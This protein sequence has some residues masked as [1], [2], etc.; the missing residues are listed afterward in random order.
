MT[1]P[2]EHYSLQPDAWRRF[3]LRASRGLLLTV[4]VFTPLAFGTSEVWSMTVAQTLI[5]S[6]ALL[7]LVALLPG[8]GAPV[9]YRVPGMAPLLLLTCFML[10]QL[11]P[12]PPFLLTWISPST[13]RIYAESVWLL[14]PGKW[15]PL[16]LYYANTLSELFRFSACVTLYFL[17]VQLLSHRKFLHRASALLALLAGSIAFFALLQKFSSPDTIYWFRHVEGGSVTGPWVYRNHYAGYMELF[18]PMTLALF[19]YSRPQVRYRLAW[20]QRLVEIFTMPEFSQHLFYGLAAVLMA[21]S[22]VVSLSR[23]GIISMC[24]ALLAFTLLAARR[25]SMTRVRLWSSVVILL[26]VLGAGWL[27]WQPVAD[28]FN[29]FFSAQGNVQLSRL[30]IWRDI[31]GILRDFPL[32]GA[33][34]GSFI[35]VFRPYR[36]LPGSLIYDHAHNDYLEV[37]TDGGLLA[38]LLALWFLGAL[39]S[40]AFSVLRKRQD[41]YSVLLALG[42]FAGL[43]SLLIHSISDFNLHNGANTF[44]FFFVCALLAAAAH[45]SRR[46]RERE[47]LLPLQQ[48]NLLLFLGLPLVGL[49]LLGSFWY[50]TGLMRG[51][52]IQRELAK[53]YLNTHMGEE[54]LRSA[55]GKADAA[56][57]RA[58]FVARHHFARANILVFQGKMDQAM[59]SFAQAI[60]LRPLDCL[61]LQRAG[62]YLTKEHPDEANRLYQAASRFNHGKVECQ[63]GHARWLFLQGRRPEGLAALRRALELDASSLQISTIMS[64]RPSP[65]ELALVLPH[66]VEP[67]LLFARHFW[68][69]NEKEKALAM[70]RRGMG[71]LSEEIE[72]R[73]NFFLTGYH[74]LRQ[75]KQDDEALAL[76]RQ[77]V[78]LMPQYADFYVLLGD[79][80]LRQGVSYRAEEEYGKALALRPDDAGIRRKLARIRGE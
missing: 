31:I 4:L 32:W 71:Y 55:L 13:A 75:M 18:L 29:S 52:R 38:G 19:L 39:V 6:A 69:K 46:E 78:E 58:P 68:E 62:Y 50:H 77:G 30:E 9:V 73:P 51:E 5:F 40:S 14:A 67:H 76:L 26:V 48:G 24:L 3:L 28:R 47:C 11:L 20:R 23:G 1:T 56:V 53:V 2:S 61:F 33:G 79:A 8:T 42:A 41:R 80:Y 12:L 72:M 25:I 54:R 45:S 57:A 27:G 44:A 70:Y 21:L 35:D 7:H 37:L 65:E 59:A 66:R 17:S 22:V 15:L 43:L 36:T 10:F 63:L 16:T 34:F 60:Q 49:M 74:W 64:Y